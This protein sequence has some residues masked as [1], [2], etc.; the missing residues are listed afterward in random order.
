VAPP[1]SFQEVPGGVEMTD[2]INYSLP[3]GILGKFANWLFVE[4]RVNAIFEYLFNVLRGKSFS[5]A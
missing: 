3:L 4:Q 1:A 5:Q 2:E